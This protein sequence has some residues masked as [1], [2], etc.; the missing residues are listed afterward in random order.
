MVSSFSAS[1]RG[2]VA[3]GGAGAAAVLLGTGVASA[4]SSYPYPL[5]GRNPFGLGVGSGEPT[6]DG[7][8]LWTRLAPEPLAADGAG[9]MPAVPVRVEYEVARDEKFRSIVKRGSVVAT[10]QLGHSAHPEIRGLEPGRTYY[11]RFRAGDEI[12]PVGRTRTAPAPGANPR[13]LNFAFASCQQ[14]QV[15]FYTAYEHMA[16]EDLDFVVH[17]GDYI[18]ETGFTSNVRGLTLGAPF[19]TETFDLPRY[20][21]QYA[22]YKSDASLMKA[23]ANFPWIQTIDDHEV[24]NNWADEI[25]QAD[26][27]PD[28]DPA[29]FR[30]RRAAAFQAM[31]ENMPLR[32]A[33]LP[34]GADVQLFR[35]LSF[36]RL[37]DIAMLDTRQYRDDQPC[38]DGSGSTC[39]DRFAADR[40]LL[41][42][43][44][45]RW[46]YD[47]FGRSKARWQIIGNQ[48]PMV[49]T[50]L[51]PSEVV[52]VYYDPWDGYVA[53][54][55]NLLAEARRR[56]VRNLVVI[57]GDR[58]QNYAADLRLDYADVNSPTVGS[59]FVGTSIT[60]G[61]NGADLP[62]S[63]QTLLDANPHIRFVNTQRGYVR[64]NVTE[65][66]WRS[67]FRV[68]PYVAT[69]GAPIST[70]ASYVVEDRHPGVTPA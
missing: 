21:A 12:S 64:V 54:R 33:Q 44:Q 11:F 18:Y 35:K 42:D 27:E 41:G 59:E 28:Q 32:S 39:A 10:P 58:H 22:L 53:E 60:T 29:V 2:F 47:G 65:Q 3:L 55:D 25:S 37:A 1:R 43:R 9:G 62:A 68:V 66:R 34:H 20:R 50:D 31:Y 26:T 56:K 30:L 4:S 40:S 49:Q 16:A 19:D 17:L 13:E 63:A 14:W 69:A 24:E 15:G 7:V 38:G 6:S 51:D 48:V 46:L 57:T 5:P 61:G 45:R 70:R 36:G 67:D 52:N 23:H 8:V